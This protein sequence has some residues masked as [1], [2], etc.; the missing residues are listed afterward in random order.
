MDTP[1]S[2]QDK[3]FQSQ[4]SEGLTARIAERQVVFNG[5]ETQDN[6][7]IAIA[8][9]RALDTQIEAERIVVVPR[10]SNLNVPNYSPK[11]D[12]QNQRAQYDMD[13][14]A[15]NTIT[16]I[17]Q[18]LSLRDSGSKPS[19]VIP[20]VFGNHWT[21]LIYHSD[22]AVKHSLV[23]MD[24]SPGLK[25]GNA[26]WRST[27]LHKFASAFEAE[28]YV[29]KVGCQVGARRCGD[30]TVANACASVHAYVQGKA[31]LKRDVASSSTPATTVDSAKKPFFPRSFF[32]SKSSRQITSSS[33]PDNGLAQQSPSEALL[34]EQ[35]CELFDKDPEQYLKCLGHYFQSIG[36]NDD[37]IQSVKAFLHQAKGSSATIDKTIQSKMAQAQTQLLGHH[38]RIC[39]EWD[40]GRWQ[41][42]AHV[43]QLLQRWQASFISALNG[44][45]ASRITY[46]SDEIYQMI[47]GKI[48]P[49]YGLDMKSD[50]LLQLKN[51][52]FLERPS[53]A[54]QQDFETALTGSGE[55]SG[56]AFNDLKQSLR[57]VSQ[58]IADP[59]MKR[60]VD[61]VCHSSVNFSHLR[62]LECIRSDTFSL[63]NPGHLSALKVVNSL[64]TGFL[65]DQGLLGTERDDKG[66]FNN[67]GTALESIRT[68]VDT[69]DVYTNVALEC[70]VLE[71][72]LKAVLEICK[73]NDANIQREACKAVMRGLQKYGLVSR[74]DRQDYRCL[75]DQY[76]SQDEF[77][78]FMSQGGEAIMQGL[79]F[80]PKVYAH[81]AR[82]MSQSGQ[83]GVS[84][85][86]DQLLASVCMFEDRSRV[87]PLLDKIDMELTKAISVVEQQ[88]SKFSGP[89][90]ATSQQRISRLQ[91]RRLLVQKQQQAV[92]GSSQLRGGVPG[93]T[94]PGR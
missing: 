32:S 51:A 77:A 12:A 35:Y 2:G 59:S 55:E 29:S 15:D 54:L 18:D 76:K 52:G 31:L 79:K 93:P 22:P 83:F 91:K 21:C 74:L 67:P 64:V 46:L 24:S 50:W 19:Y 34:A 36:L 65:G 92:G 68:Y 11:N 81:M 39:T 72:N 27:C 71:D 26:Q 66:N 3:F 42:S 58:K 88:E 70:T 7:D 53:V 37:A 25:G 40:Y 23:Y 56:V 82:E 1:G 85:P 60:L 17:Q 10:F 41:S 73:G 84:K 90:K 30:W 43:Q 47:S 9:M 38:L 49:I 89:D 5:N 6:A 80:N 28:I 45:D 20:V 61:D 69:H 57:G 44:G 63:D 48:I 4:H 62:Y 16:R 75:R 78:H 8:L 87:M 33:P 94:R 14:W 86:F 13:A